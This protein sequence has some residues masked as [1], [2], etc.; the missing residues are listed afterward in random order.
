MSSL[1]QQTAARTCTQC[2]NAK[3]KCDKL[4]PACSRCLR[5]TI[6]CQYENEGSG[7][8]ESTIE[9]D[10]A[11]FDEIFRRLDR[12]EG[13]VSGFGSIPSPYGSHGPTVMNDMDSR[14]L[15][16]PH[17]WAVDP[18][19][20]KSDYLGFILWGSVFRTLNE[21]KTTV[22]AI[23]KAYLEYTHPWL[24]IVCSVRFENN[25]KRFKELRP[26]LGFLLTILAMHLV[27]T[28]P[29]NHPS[30]KSL[31]ES[32]W[33]RACKHYFMHFV[34]LVEPSIDL[35]QAGI[36]I[37]LFEHVQCIEDRALITLGICGRLAYELDFDD[38]VSRELAIELEERSLEAIEVL[39]TWIGIVLLDRYMNMPP[40]ETPKHPILR[41]RGSQISFLE[42]HLIGNPQITASNHGYRNSCMD[43]LEAALLL[44]K[45]HNIIRDHRNKSIDTLPDIPQPLIQ[46]VMFILSRDRM[47]REETF[48]ACG[49]TAVAVSS[50][51][52]MHIWSVR[53]KGSLD[54]HNRTVILDYVESLRLVFSRCRTVNG[55][56]ENYYE[57]IQPSWISVAFQAV[58][59]YKLVHTAYPEFRTDMDTSVFMELLS[60]LAERYKLAERCLEIIY[61]AYC[62]PN[63]PAQQL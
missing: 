4:L 13:R 41:N 21:D 11:K 18:G 10:A 23:H 33:Y 62:D 51:L 22:E 30:A 24:P 37:A 16:D 43:D 34:G 45:V 57:G 26:D 20:L 39:Q 27:V 7:P 49:A 25:H 54:E 55:F 48:R 2:K 59:A 31:S 32:P 36:L 5:V 53:K 56:T 29:S 38:I 60:A 35:I 58:M 15:G 28:S 14:S 3:K 9:S 19:Q 63:A 46:E 1:D 61:N 6:Q 50:V 17:K 42:V 12:I 44:A 47:Q 52:Q 40:A 8:K